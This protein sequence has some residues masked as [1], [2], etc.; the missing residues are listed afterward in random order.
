MSLL[1]PIL[2]ISLVHVPGVKGGR[3]ATTGLTGIWCLPLPVDLLSAASLP[4]ST[5][6]LAAQFSLL[7]LFSLRVTVGFRSRREDRVQLSPRIFP[8]ADQSVAWL[9]VLVLY[10]RERERAQHYQV[11]VK[12]FRSVEH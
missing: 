7:L 3:T 6:P 12:I 8:P 9:W 1:K 5:Y 11:M 10:E 2:A 4:F